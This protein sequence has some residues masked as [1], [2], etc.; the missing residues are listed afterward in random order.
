MSSLDCHPK[1]D[2]YVSGFTAIG[3]YTEVRLLEPTLKKL[4][5]WTVGET[6]T[7]VRGKDV[8]KIR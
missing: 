3:W 8:L 6:S 1:D 5:K 4:K 7:T 2:L